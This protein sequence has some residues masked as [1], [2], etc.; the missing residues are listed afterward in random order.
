M[1]VEREINLLKHELEV[2]ERQ[3]QQ[4]AARIRVLEEWVDV[5]SSPLWKRVWF[6]ICGWNWSTLGRWYRK[7][8]WKG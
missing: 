7:D 8:L 2:K 5:V 1:D 3:R 6:F 4:M